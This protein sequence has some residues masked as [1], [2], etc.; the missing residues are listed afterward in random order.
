MTW[1]Q[2]VKYYIKKFIL[3]FSFLPGSVQDCALELTGI[4]LINLVAIAFYLLGVEIMAVSIV[5]AFLVILF[6]V[7]RETTYWETMKKRKTMKSVA[8][9]LPRLKPSAS[10][11]NKQALKFE[12]LNNDFDNRVLYKSKFNTVRD[13][14]NE[15]GPSTKSNRRML[16]QIKV[17]Q[18]KRANVNAP[19]TSGGSVS[20]QQSVG[21]PL[22]LDVANLPPPVLSPSKSPPRA[23]VPRIDTTKIGSLANSPAREE[24]KSPAEVEDSKV[25]DDEFAYA[26]PSEAE[27]AALKAKRKAAKKSKKRLNRLRESGDDGASD[28][29]G[30][31]AQSAAEE[32]DTGRSS[33]LNTHLQRQNRRKEKHRHKES[34]M[35]GPGIS[36]ARHFDESHSTVTGM[37]RQSAAASPQ[38][39]HNLMDLI[40]V[41]VN[42]ELPQI[43]Y[44]R[45]NNNSIYTRNPDAGPGGRMQPGSGQSVNSYGNSTE[46]SRPQFP[47]WH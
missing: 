1:F 20:S 43:D 30:S 25:S 14:D 11:A 31:R 26:I 21:T 37:T 12:E 4:L 40:R 33:Q 9:Y 39:R 35:G 45:G 2:R 23:A 42:S 15:F 3:V 8:R 38:D 47:S 22:V 27:K 41:D 7:L 46:Y 13:T 28:V 18:Q 19:F 36:S 6:F 17:Q 24:M 16:R 44:F 10:Q 29:G 5:I 32:P 34:E